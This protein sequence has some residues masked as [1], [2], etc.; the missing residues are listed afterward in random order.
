MIYRYYIYYHYYN[1]ANKRTVRRRLNVKAWNR[2][3]NIVY[4]K[5]YRRTDEHGG[6]HKAFQRAHEFL[7][8]DEIDQDHGIDHDGAKMEGKLRLLQDQSA[9][10]RSLH[11]ERKMKQLER[12]QHPKHGLLHHRL[13]NAEFADQ[14]DGK[15]NQNR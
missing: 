1:I 5:F 9:V 7:I 11:R 3:K 4:R 10:G 15:S 2:N 13:R 6:N 14:N 8:L 12:D